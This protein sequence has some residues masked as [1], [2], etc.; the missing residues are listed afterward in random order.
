MVFILKSLK[1]ELKI[2]IG[3]SHDKHEKSI[4]IRIVSNTVLFLT[5]LSNRYSNHK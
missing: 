2:E 3:K 4:I 5:M 1:M